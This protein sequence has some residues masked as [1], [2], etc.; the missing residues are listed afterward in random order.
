[1]AKAIYLPKTREYDVY[2]LNRNAKEQP[3][4]I[5]SWV[6]YGDMHYD[7]FELLK[8]EEEYF[9]FTI[10]RHQESSW[11]GKKLKPNE[12]E[13]LL[14]ADYNFVVDFWESKGI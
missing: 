1:M 6:K 12:V 4:K 11:M 3:E 5:K 14:E 10:G 9:L 2:A 13:D 8:Q 7:H